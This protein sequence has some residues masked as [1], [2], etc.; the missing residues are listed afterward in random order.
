MSHNFTIE[1]AT[2]IERGTDKEN[3][4]Y[5]LIKFKELKNPVPFY[6]LKTAEEPQRREMWERLEAGEFGEITWPPSHYP[7]HPLTQLQLE[8]VERENRNDLLM[9]S[10]WTQVPDA[11]ISSELKAKWSDYR[12]ALRD[13]P[14]QPGF[15][16]EIEWPVKP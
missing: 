7:R 10:D 2:Q 1:G 13:L 6:A 3:D 15:P 16:Y 12:Q 8:E 9:K 4:I 11:P 5:C 14:D